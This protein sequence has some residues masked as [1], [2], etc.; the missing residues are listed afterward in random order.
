MRRGGEHAA[1]R[2]ARA[3]RLSRARKVLDYNA[4]GLGAGYMTGDVSAEA[5]ES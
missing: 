1:Q 4:K 2:Q 5:S 3:G